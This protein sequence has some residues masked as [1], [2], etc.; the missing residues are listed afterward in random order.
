M[1]DERFYFNLQATLYSSIMSVR[2]Y[3]QTTRLFLWRR[4]LSIREMRN[5]II[6]VRLS[7]RRRTNSRRRQTCLQRTLRW[8]HQHCQ[9]SITV[10]PMFFRLLNWTLDD[11][12]ERLDICYPMLSWSIEDIRTF[13]DSEPIIG[14]VT[15]VVISFSE[16]KIMRNERFFVNLQASLYSSIMSVRRYETSTR[17]ALWEQTLKIRNMRNRILLVRSSLRRRTT[18]RRQRTLIRTLKWC[19]GR[20][21][22]LEEEQ[23]RTVDA[24]EIVN[25]LATQLADTTG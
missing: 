24:I 5:Q 15:N 25:S 3:T 6:R 4:T 18:P 10:E 9:K 19:W 17:V 7:L 2:R 21:Q 1:R 23:Q 11:L 14:R 8:Y 13:V 16:H 20:V 22:M 12:K